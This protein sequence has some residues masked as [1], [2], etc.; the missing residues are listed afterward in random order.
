MTGQLLTT[1]LKRSGKFTVVG[2][3]T[4]AEGGW[5][6]C[7]AQHPEVVLLDVGLSGEDGLALAKRLQGLKPQPRILVVS[8]REDAYMLHRMSQLDLPGY[9]SKTSSL[10]TFQEALEAMVQGRRFYSAPFAHCL[11]QQDAFFR[12]LTGR[13]RQVL[14]ATAAGLSAE[15]LS[16][17][18]HLACST[19]HKH[20]D[21]MRRKLGMHSH[22][23]LLRYATHIGMNL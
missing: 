19:V 1:C 2:C 12:I 9:V 10:A 16:R 23:E 18:F 17:K 3:A 14:Q 8:G 21:N 4:S 13:E 5:S 22:A 15:E 20:F 11:Q 7:A 6:L